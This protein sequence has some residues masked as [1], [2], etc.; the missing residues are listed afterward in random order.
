MRLVN[1]SLA[2]LEEEQIMNHQVCMAM[3][4]VA[5]LMMSNNR[6]RLK[7]IEI[8]I[9]A[10]A[11]ITHSDSMLVQVMIMSNSNNLHMEVG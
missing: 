7:R 1:S 10:M 11:K 9:E 3:R 2:I 6:R 5:H 4:K 8:I